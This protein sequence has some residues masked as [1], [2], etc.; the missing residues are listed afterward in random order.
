MNALS[1]HVPRSPP[2][3][4]TTTAAR[5]GLTSLRAMKFGFDAQPSGL[6]CQRQN[7]PSIQVRRYLRE[8]FGS[9]GKR[10]LSFRWINS[11]LKL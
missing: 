7:S 1:R 3:E 6:L 8:D 11:D 10:V 4:S 5:T 2:Y 9:G